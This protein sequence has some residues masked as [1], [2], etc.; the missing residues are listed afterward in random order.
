MA[1]FNVHLY[2]EFKIRLDNIKA[3]N[4]EEAA[5]I[6]LKL[7][8]SGHPVDD[9]PQECDGFI[10]SALVDD[11]TDSDMPEDGTPVTFYKLIEES[12][13]K[14]IKITVKGGCVQEVE[15]LPEGWDYELDDQD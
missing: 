15:N 14:T 6:A 1:Q 11:V 13:N 2:R 8:E 5:R 10:T 4:P 7:I 9:G 3:T 12:P